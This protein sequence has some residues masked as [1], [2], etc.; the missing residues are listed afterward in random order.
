M[1][2]KKEVTFCNDFFVADSSTLTK[3]PRRQ[4][5]TDGES[6]LPG[7]N[8]GAHAPQPISTPPPTKQGSSSPRFYFLPHAGEAA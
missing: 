6:E 3:C 1:Y 7:T 4:V 5:V 8:R 2:L